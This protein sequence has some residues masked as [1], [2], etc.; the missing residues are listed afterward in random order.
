MQTC[1]QC[2]HENGADDKYCANCGTKLPGQSPSINEPESTPPA[3]PNWADGKTQ[4]NE[5]PTPPS[6]SIPP[7]VE[8][9]PVGQGPS[10]EDEWRMSSL[11]PPPKRRRIWLW[12]IIGLIALCMLICVGFAVYVQTDSG[13]NWWSDFQTQVADEATKAA[14]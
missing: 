3:T 12:V 13:S 2:G 8:F 7:P 6:G 10:V 11:G 5:T 14:D 1:T 4:S 9:R